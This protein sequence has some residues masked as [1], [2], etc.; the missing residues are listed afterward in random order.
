M[1][2][3]EKPHSCVL[4]ILQ[5]SFNRSKNKQLTVT[6]QIISET[7]VAQ[8]GAE[9]YSVRGL[10]HLFRISAQRYN[11]SV[12]VRICTTTDGNTLERQTSFLVFVFIRRMPEQ[13]SSAP[14]VRCLACCVYVYLSA[15]TTVV[16]SQSTDERISI[17]LPRTHNIRTDFN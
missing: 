15:A 9:N 17:R 3:T 2:K 5:N 13:P 6:A 1:E 11:A 12:V 7:V 16:K 4:G 8:F 14:L 10:T